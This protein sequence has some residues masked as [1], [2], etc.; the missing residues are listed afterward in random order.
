[1]G[2]RIFTGAVAMLLFIPV[3]YFSD[4]IAFP[5]VLGLLSGIAFYEFAVC[6]GFT[7]NKLFAVSPIIVLSALLPI[8]ARNGQ[9]WL[10]II[11]LSV[12]VYLL[13]LFV[14]GH[15]RIE[16]PSVTALFFGFV[17]AG[18]SFAL[19]V[20]V[21]DR[22]PERYLLIFIA[23]WCT[24]TFAYF[25]GR[26]FGDRKLC[27]SLSPKKTIAGAVSGVIGAIIGFA[28]FGLIIVSFGGGFPFWKYCLIAIPASV[29]AQLGDLAASAIKRH[30]VIKDYGS[31]F[32]GHGG[33]LDRFDS[34]LPLS[35][36]AFLVLSLI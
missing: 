5:I 28:V 31:I 34:I 22:V 3:L 12:F 17:Y 21:R 35:V 20:M 33:V 15:G 27:P 4:S 10:V 18:V 11:G 2:K 23:A 14:L 6:A 32:P 29:A 24:D 16:V 13:F 30:Y 8:L 25:G 9:Q 7:G 26:L 1:M 36:G 19:L